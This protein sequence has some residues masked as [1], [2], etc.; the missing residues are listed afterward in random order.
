MTAM[1]DRLMQPGQTAAYHPWGTGDTPM[2][3][4]LAV[5]TFHQDGATY[6]D[7]CPLYTGDVNAAPLPATAPGSWGQVH[8]AGRP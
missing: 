3:M 6:Q 2:V 7:L 5:V 1:R 4:P 8:A